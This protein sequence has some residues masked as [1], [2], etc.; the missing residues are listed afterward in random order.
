MEEQAWRKEQLA[1]ARNEVN[2]CLM[3]ENLPCISADNDITLKTG[4]GTMCGRFLQF[5]P[6]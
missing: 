4:T 2:E 3:E 6:R 5:F 1:E